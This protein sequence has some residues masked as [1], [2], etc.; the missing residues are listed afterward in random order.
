MDHSPRSS[1]RRGLAVLVL[2][3]VL[4]AAGVLAL[5]VG[6]VPSA[7]DLPTPTPH[8][9]EETPY[10]LDVVGGADT[11]VTT[12]PPA[13]IDG[14]SFGATQ[15]I[16][17][18]PRGMEFRVRVT[19][20][21]APIRD[22]VLFVRFVHGSGTRAVAEY[23]AEADE[24]VARIWE[25]GNMQ[26]AWTPLT[27]SWRA[28]D[29]EGNSADT[30][31]YPADY[32]DTGREW[33][34]MESEHVI[35]YWFGFGED[36]PDAIAQQMADA[37]AATHPRR[38]EGFGRPLSYKPVAVVYPDRATLAET[39]GSGV[40]SDRFAGITSSEWGMS[41]QVLRDADYAPGNE[42]CIWARPPE[43]WTME[44]RINTIYSVT[45]HEV[46]HLYQYDVLGGSLGPQWWAEGQADWFS[47]APGL[48]DSRLRHLGTLQD[49]PSLT[50]DV[51]WNFIEA[52]GCYRLAYDMGASFI[53]YLLAHYGG[54]ETHRQI[55]QAMRGGRSVYDAI[56]EVTGKPF[57]EVE[58]E[59]RTYLGW[60][61][62][63]VA[64]VDPAAALEP[65]LD[66]T[67]AVGDVVTLPSTPAMSPLYE[68]PG[69]RVLANAS[70][71]AGMP[72]TILRAESLD[73]VDYYEVDCMGMTG[74]MTRDQLVGTQ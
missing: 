35:L 55:A 57:L 54:L 40:T 15:A 26:P 12:A 28:R 16:S 25:T 50:G 52:D 4:M 20:E 49:M 41:I 36:D 63:E 62:L 24:W 2:L 31:P 59:W 70:C 71:F 30:E 34:R 73:G 29:A 45:T 68:K 33:F 69:P 14:F 42:N 1:F 13:E 51:G 7:Q 66:T 38:V 39:V 60:P 58:N 27:F 67:F 10:T 56:E 23:E 65:P 43:E 46:A 64:D 47:L 37:M 44:R 17:R 22:V 11:E 21:D 72:V 8:P 74:W 5:P 32:A 53:N 19:S 48:Y 9:V 18:Y 61:A 6:A 3:A